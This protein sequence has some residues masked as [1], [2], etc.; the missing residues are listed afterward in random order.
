[1]PR[2][3]SRLLSP[4]CWNPMEKAFWGEDKRFKNRKTIFRGVSN[5]RSVA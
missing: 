3:R 5:Q 2:M 1:M 4:L